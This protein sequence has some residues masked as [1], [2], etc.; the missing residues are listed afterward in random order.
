MI[1]DSNFLIYLVIFVK[2]SLIDYCWLFLLVVFD[3]DIFYCCG[4]V[5]GDVDGLFCIFVSDEESNWD[6]LFDE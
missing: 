3:F 1:I 4:K 2:L 5:N 6:V